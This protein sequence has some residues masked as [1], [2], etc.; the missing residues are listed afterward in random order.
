M[1]LLLHDTGSK[2]DYNRDIVSIE[3]AC[4]SSSETL[5]FGP[6]GVFSL[7]VR[8]G[9]GAASDEVG[10]EMQ[11][12]E[13]SHANGTPEGHD[14]DFFLHETSTQ[15]DDAAGPNNLLNHELP[16]LMDDQSCAL[17]FDFISAPDPNTVWTNLDWRHSPMTLHEGSVPT[18]PEEIQATLISSESDAEDLQ[19]DSAAMMCPTLSHFRT[20]NDPLP[21]IEALTDLFKNSYARPGS[22]W[23]VLQMPEIQKTLGQIALRLTPSHA[24]YAVLYAVLAVM[25]FHMDR[26]NTTEPRSGYW[27]TLGGDYMSQA[28]A[29]VKLLL[30][31]TPFSLDNTGYKSTVMALLTMVAV[32]V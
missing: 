5:T 32:C 25:S 9:S 17:S 10:R 16:D 29:Q 30:A 12:P 1:C 27:W 22:T 18:I 15:M 24:S 13:I 8:P 11:I 7:N 21:H 4:N 20:R 31:N 6:F 3:E 2:I 19:C 26:L 28:V 14:L 23:Q